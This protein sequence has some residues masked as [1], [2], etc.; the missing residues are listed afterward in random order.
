LS[1]GS[2]LSETW[3]QRGLWLLAI[4]FAGFLIGLG[5]L[6]VAD[7]PQVE[8][9]VNA[10]SFMDRS[11]LLV[12]RAQLRDDDQALKNNQDSLDRQSLVLRA[13]TEEAD[14]TKD[15]F[16]NWVATRSAT[17]HSNQDAEVISRTHQLDELKAKQRALEVEQ[18]KLQQDRLAL[19]Q[20]NAMHH[21]AEQ[22][23][24]AAGNAGY[25]RAL[26]KLEMRVFLLRLAITLPLLLIS[27]LLFFKARK[28]AYWP[29]V[30]GFI[31]FSLFTFF[32]ELVPYLPSYGG[33]V[34]YIVGIV[35]TTFVGLYSIR[36]LQRYLEQQRSAE[37]KPEEE[38]RKDLSY[39]V[40]QSRIAKNICPG[41]ERPFDT[42]DP[43][44]NFCMNCGLLVFQNCV[45]CTVRRTVFAH[46]CRSCGSRQAVIELSPRTPTQPQI[47]THQ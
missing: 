41:C 17:Q 28:T 44:N 11:Q 2:R 45:V 37:Q 35:L 24:E 14:N 26:R 25:E 38:R 1:K 13:A 34:R 4:I 15:T 19:Q 16:N 8:K 21:T 3:F 43:S 40:A 23:I 33:Y 9:P 7:L 32:V 5:S 22:K 18:D 39:D 6:I 46:F 20:A 29:F 36:A 10:E 31:F 47:I 12:T 42:S 30:W 27:I